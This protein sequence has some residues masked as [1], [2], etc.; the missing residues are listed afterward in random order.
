MVTEDLIGHLESWEEHALRA[1]EAWSHG[2]PAPI[3]R[4]LRTEGLT[5]VNR[6]EVVWKSRRSARMA[7]DRAASTRVRLLTS[8]GELSETRWRAPATPRGR[9][10]LGHRLGQ[11]LVGTRE[12]F[13]H[14]E[15]HLKDL[16][17]FVEDHGV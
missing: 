5:E 13:R 16:S 10:P 6:A 17:A 9:V 11:I 2:N 8:I 4:L 7:L 12:P 1:L 14:D 15:A 3:D